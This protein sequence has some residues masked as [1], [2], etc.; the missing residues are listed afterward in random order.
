M[1]IQGAICYG[2]SGRCHLSDFLEVEVQ[3][4][5]IVHK[6]VDGHITYI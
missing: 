3:T 1:F 2:Y 6:A 4:L 5:E